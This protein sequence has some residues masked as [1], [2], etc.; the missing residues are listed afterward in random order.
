MSLF[1]R[2]PQNENRTCY[3][4]ACGDYVVPWQYDSAWKLCLAHAAAAQFEHDEYLRQQQ[5]AQAK[6]G[7][8]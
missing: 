2:K 4:S 8:R 7:K 6:G 5:P 1:T 3:C